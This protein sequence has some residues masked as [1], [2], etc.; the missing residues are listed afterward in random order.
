MLLLMGYRQRASGAPHDVSVNMTAAKFGQHGVTTPLKIFRPIAACIP[1]P[2]RVSEYVRSR[3][4]RV[5]AAGV[6]IAAQGA[7]PKELSGCIAGLYRQSHSW[8]TNPG[9]TRHS[10]ILA[11]RGQLLRR[12]TWLA[13]AAVPMVDVA[14]DV[15]IPP[16]ARAQSAA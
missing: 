13:A 14:G 4:K 7:Q 6:P 9:F 1:R 3:F 2:L 15:T 16:A 12:S 8:I 10:D 5:P 11:L